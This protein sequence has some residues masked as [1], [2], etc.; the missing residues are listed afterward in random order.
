MSID[1]ELQLIR[2]KHNELM[3]AELTAAEVRY[4]AD[5]FPHAYVKS[6]GVEHTAD[7]TVFVVN[8]FGL[9]FKN[10]QY[11][12]CNYEFNKLPPVE[13]IEVFADRIHRVEE[14]SE[15][16]YKYR[17]LQALYMHIAEHHHKELSAEEMLE[18]YRQAC[19]FPVESGNREKQGFHSWLLT[20]SY[21][22]DDS[23]HL[24]Q[25]LLRWEHRNTFIAL[26]T[27]ENE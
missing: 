22:G 8:D 24:G 6:I 9:S 13:I 17:A 18:L 4:Y 2:T 15:H 23:G 3:R 7:L 5:K 21:C 12:N 14:C 27:K 19:G 20:S 16:I 11:N 25:K 1:K 10:D 26:V